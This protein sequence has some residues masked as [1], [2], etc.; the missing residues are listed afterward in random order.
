MSRKDAELKEMI[1]ET[2]VYLGIGLSNIINI[3]DP[4]RVIVGGGISN[5]KQLFPIALKEA[6]KRAF[7][8]YGKRVEIVVSSLDDAGIIGAASIIK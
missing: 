5:I 4:N 2:G 3:F 7:T 6:K 1:K 8:P